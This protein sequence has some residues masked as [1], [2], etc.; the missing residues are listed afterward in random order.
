VNAKAKSVAMPN[1][2]AILLRFY[3]LAKY[4]QKCFAKI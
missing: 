1:K 2:R 4:I 3:K